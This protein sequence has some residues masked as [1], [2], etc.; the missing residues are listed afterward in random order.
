M[1][2]AT[3]RLWPWLWA[4]GAAAFVL[5]ARLH[6]IHGHTGAV[7]INDQW[8]IEAADILAPWIDGS[9][10]PTAFFA[11][12]FEHVPMWTRLLAWLQAALTG[13]WD[14]FAQT[15]V[16]ALLHAS[17]CAIAVHF[18][19]RHL[20]AL[21]AAF[22]TAAVIGVAALPYAWENITWGFQSQFPLALLFLFL[23]VHGSIENPPGTR[24][25]WFAQGAGLAGLFTLA[26]MWM[27]PL[28]V[29]LAAAWTRAPLSRWAAVPAAL[30]A[31]GLA[32]IALIKATA[33]SYGAFAQ[34]A[35]SPL[36]FLHAFLDL[37]GWPAGWPGA[38]AITMLPF[39]VFVF[40]SRG[41]RDAS[42]FDRIV[43]ALG[44]WAI[45]QAAALAF[46]RGA[47]YGGYVS[48]YG[49]LLAVFVLVNALALTRLGTGPRLA[50][51]AV[52]VF[53]A[54]WALTISL[55]LRDLS[56]GG[57]TA[58]FHAHAAENNRARL[59]AVQAYL[60][61]HDRALL[62]QPAT[63]H[64]LYQDVNQVTTLLDRPSFRALL[65]HEVEPANPPD[66]AGRVVRAA[67]RHSLA[68][69]LG[70]SLALIVG[71]VGVAFGSAAREPLAP[72]D[73]RRDRWLPRSAFL[74]AGLAGAGVFAWPHPFTF[75]VEQRWHRFFHSP[76]SV[77]FLNYQIISGNSV[78]PPGR[79]A[80]TAP[81]SP[82]ELRHQFAGTDVDGPGFTC[83][84]WSDPFPIRTPWF[85]VP[86]AGWPISHGNG[87]RL[88]V[89]TSDGQ[90]IQEIG[91]GSTTAPEVEFTA[92]DTSTFI[93]R[94]ARVVLYDG[95][96]DTEGWVAAAPPIAAA[97]PEL[98][99]ALARGF[100]H[101]RLA[102]AHTAF[103]WIAVGALIA[104]SAAV[105]APRLFGGET[106]NFFGR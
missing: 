18:I 64:A 54:A 99:Q 2:P 61:H 77:G 103:L 101:E 72:F 6:E 55:G 56:I 30:A 28:A 14:P 95:R 80:G 16:N 34:T 87:L 13:R 75:G 36:H 25:W 12:H 4:G 23:H 68:L 20:R 105:A 102:P 45:G 79:L 96:T 69:G 93:G 26:G 43:L 60:A 62:E 98:A 24:A 81:L 85:I 53:G 58:Y 71:F 10:R 48:R 51:A 27:A 106:K 29:L 84:A 17:F 44:L 15:T 91:C 57:H 21:P 59:D 76:D 1:T 65:P 78:Q 97:Q 49:E 82:E 94:R 67:Q 11:P 3:A 46:A 47:D 104:G 42:P 89:E 9:L 5:A 7:A 100:A 70:A 31:T 22:A 38:V 92:L 66:L 74:V 90:L 86:H 52:L 63:R 73:W 32:I 19:V 50:R 37:L 88:R 83:T 40:Q 35:S 39:T 8:K 41:R 33:P